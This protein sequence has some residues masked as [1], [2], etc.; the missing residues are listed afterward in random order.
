MVEHPGGY[1]IL[2]SRGA[3]RDLI[4]QLAETPLAYIAG[5]GALADGLVL[6]FVR[7]YLTYPS[8]FSALV[9][10]LDRH[11]AVRYKSG[12]GVQIVE[13]DAGLLG[14]SSKLG[15]SITPRQFVLLEQATEACDRDMSGQQILAV[16]C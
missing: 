14:P 7:L 4:G 13:P 8:K 12:L 11:R 6:H 9:G 1:L 2:G 10:I 3:Q 16:L 5:G 15:V